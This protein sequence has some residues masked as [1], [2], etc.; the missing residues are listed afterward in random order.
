[1]HLVDVMN[2]LGEALDVIEGLRV[3]PYTEKRVNPPQAS[4]TLPRRLSYDSTMGRGSDDIEIPVVVFVGQVD[5]EAARNAIGQYVDGVG[6]G[7]VK[8]AIESHVT[9]AYDIAHVLDVDFL[10][11]TVAGIDYQTAMFRVRVVGKG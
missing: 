6:G 3:K 8:D 2:A 10:V 11:M 1:M 7:S 5:A 4:V 9:T